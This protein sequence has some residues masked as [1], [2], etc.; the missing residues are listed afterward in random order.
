MIC[1]RLFAVGLLAAVP[2]AGWSYDSAFTLTFE[3]ATDSEGFTDTAG[4]N[5]V[6]VA[7][8]N[9]PADAPP[10]D[11]PP[12]TATQYNGT[13]WL[14]TGS[15]VQLNGVSTA[16]YDG[17]AGGTTQDATDFVATVDMYINPTYAERYQVGLVG[18]WTSGFGPFH[19]FYSRKTSTL[20]DGYGWRGGG[21][22]ASAYDGFAAG[23]ETVAKWVRVKLTME[24]STARA[25]IDQNLDGT[26][27]L[28][29]PD[30]TV[31]AP[32][33][34][35]IGV[36]SVINTSAGLRIPDQWA[37]YDNLTYTPLASVSE[38]SLY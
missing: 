9:T 15:D 22:S 7:G 31:A 17:R 12:N 16:V 21:V 34:G 13:K 2:V 18:R 30:I 36:Q 4:N 1:T 19:V 32:V 38:W 24:G 33:A 29:S 25:S 8:E 5:T 28:N 3:Q 20:P 26:Y 11:V 35:K 14:R 10:Y 23:P 27:D 37:Y 6:F